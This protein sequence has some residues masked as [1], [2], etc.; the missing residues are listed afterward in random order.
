[1]ECRARPGRKRPRPHVALADD[2]LHA[3]RSVCSQLSLCA[4]RRC[5]CAAERELEEPRDLLWLDIHLRR[6]L[7]AIDD[8]R[9]GMAIRGRALAGGDIESR[10]TRGKAREHDGKR[11]SSDHERFF[12]VQWSVLRGRSSTFTHQ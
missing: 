12:P 1:Q 4:C 7:V 11:N 6:D 8:E 3:L 2:L 9:P 5:L 10:Y